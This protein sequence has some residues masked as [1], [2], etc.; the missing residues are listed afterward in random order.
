MQLDEPAECASGSD[1]LLLYK[2]LHLVFSS[3]VWILCALRLESRKK[4]INMVLMRDLW[5]FSFFGRGDVSPTHSEL[6]RFVSG[7]QATHQVSSTVIILLKNFVCIGHRDNILARCDSIFPLL[8]CQ[9]VWNKTCTQLSLSQILFQ[10]PKNYSLWDVQ[11][12]CYHSWF[13]SDAIFD[14]IS[15]SSNVYLSSSRFWTATSLVFFY[16]LPSVLKSRTPPKNVCS[17]HSLIP[18]SL[19]HQY[20]C[21]CHRQTGFKT[22]FYGNSLFI[23]AIHDV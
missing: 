8:R 22:K 12:F 16:Q 11:R 18:I 13:D 5:K 9:A 3:L 2:I 6:C 21:F 20:W 19:L 4:N 15:N 7:S 14:Q 23:S 10:N 17:V 1:Q